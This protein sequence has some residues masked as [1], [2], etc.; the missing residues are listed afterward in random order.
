[1]NSFRG[2]SKVDQWIE[3]GYEYNQIH[4]CVRIFFERTFLSFY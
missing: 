2:K 3:Y 1:M 4:L